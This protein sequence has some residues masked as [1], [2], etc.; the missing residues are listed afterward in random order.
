V[1]ACLVSGSVDSVEHLGIANLLQLQRLEA[2]SSSLQQPELLSA[3]SNLAQLDHISL[4]YGDAQSAVRAAAAWRHLSGLRALCLEEGEDPT[5]LGPADSLALAQGLAAATSLTSL[6]IVGRI[7]HDS[8]QLCAHLA[9]LTQLQRLEMHGGEHPCSRADALHLTALMNLT[10]LNLCGALGVDDTAAC[11]LA[12]RLTKLQDLQLWLC[13]LSSPAVLPVIAS[14]TALTNLLLTHDPETLDQN[15]SL[16]LGRDDLLLL[17]PLTQLKQLRC[18]NFFSDEA[19]GE[20][21]DAGSKQW[22]QQ[23][24]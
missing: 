16:P 19:M 20:L 1:R 6:G 17:A 21:W 5:P 13:N 2:G 23:Q 24:Q 15:D 12:V 18:R 4:S 11:A 8:V 10:K 3:L 14:L 7:V 9:G 22:Q